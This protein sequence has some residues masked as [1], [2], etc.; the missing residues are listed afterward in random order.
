MPYGYGSAN[1]GS[2][3]Q[4][5]AGGA[6][7]GGNY[8]GN[9][10]PQQRST[11]APTYRNVHQTGAVTQ[12]PGRTSTVTTASGPPGILNPPTPPTTVT[13]AAGPPGILSRP[14]RGRINTT[15]GITS[16]DVL[17]RFLKHRMNTQLMKGMVLSNYAPEYTHALGG[18]DWKQ[19]FPETPEWLDKALA[20]GYQHITEIPRGIMNID[21]MSSIYSDTGIIGSL[22]NAFNKA[23]VEAAKNIQGFTGETIP[24]ETLEK[25]HN[26]QNLARGGLANLY[27]YGGFSG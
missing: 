21:P 17:K 7:A 9:R 11:P 5:P 18:Y 23:N 25:Y 24:P 26:W 10:N 14:P 27:R 4:G 12:T 8:G 3:N 15:G 16:T 6:S 2:T 22:S 1:R 19:N 20:Y 13:T